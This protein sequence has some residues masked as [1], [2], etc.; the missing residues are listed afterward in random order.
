MTKNN[1]YST[2]NHNLCEQQIKH[3]CLYRFRNAY[4][5]DEHFKILHDTPTRKQSVKYKKYNKIS[6]LNPNMTRKSTVKK[7]QKTV[8]EILTQIKIDSKAGKNI[9]NEKVFLSQRST[10]QQQNIHPIT[11]SVIDTELKIT[12]AKEPDNLSMSRNTTCIT[13]NTNILMTQC[14]ILNQV[15]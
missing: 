13:Y 5:T 7:E 10:R 15:K 14:T 3:V 12:P 2:T 9:D 8:A 11:Y 6:N 1:S 4:A